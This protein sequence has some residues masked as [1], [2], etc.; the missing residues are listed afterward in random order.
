MTIGENIRMLRQKRN[1]SQKEL[2]ETIHVRPQT[3]SSWEVN[4]TEPN[5]GAIELLAD[6][7]HCRKSDIIGDRTQDIALTTEEIELIL[8]FRASDPARQGIIKE[9]LGVDRR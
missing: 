6:A 7:L 8:A 4:R 1:I 9:L 5:M 3:V 2:A